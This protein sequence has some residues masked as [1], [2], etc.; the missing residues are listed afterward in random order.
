MNKEKAE[1]VVN[2]IK[3]DPTRHDQS[4]WTNICATPGYDH[5]V[6]VDPDYGTPKVKETEDQII[7]CGTTACLAGHTGFIFAPVGTKFYK[8]SMRLPVSCSVSG[9]LRT[10]ISYEDF[11]REE[12][13]LDSNETAYLFS[14]IRSLEEI[15]EFLEA[16]D[17]QREGILEDNEL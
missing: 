8:D 4:I 16:T 13:E 11:A 3:A 15:Q 2:A 1:I 17:E 6:D 5:G 14:G 10:L 9:R 12:L 7:N